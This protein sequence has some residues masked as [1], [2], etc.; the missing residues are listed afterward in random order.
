MPALAKIYFYISGGTNV[1]SALQN[2]IFRALDDNGVSILGVSFHDCEADLGTSGNQIVLEAAEQAAAQGITR[3]NSSDD[4]GSA[5][6]DDFTTASQATLGFAVNGYASPPY[7]VAVGG[8]DF[9]VLSSSFSTYANGEITDIPPYYRTA[10]GYIPENP[11]NNSTT[12]NNALSNN[13]A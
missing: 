10:V 6:C 5:G 11:W 8:S 12:I 13:I 2:A 4:G 1:S 9:D 3:V 7:T